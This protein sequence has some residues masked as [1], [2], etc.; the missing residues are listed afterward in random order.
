MI[1]SFRHKVLERFFHTGAIAGIQAS[2]ARRLRLILGRLHAASSPQDMNLPGLRLHELSGK[3][4]GT[5]A[6]NVSGNW[7]VTFRF[8]GIDAEVVDYED[9]H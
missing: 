6:V 1:R 2:H 8:N 9:Y 3:R 4:K 7:R 5:W